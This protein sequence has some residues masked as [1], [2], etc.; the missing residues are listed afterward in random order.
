MKRSSW[1]LAGIL[2]VPLAAIVVT[3][4]RADTVTFASGKVIEDVQTTE[5]GD[6]IRIIKSDGSAMTY[7]KSMIAKIEKRATAAQEL[8]ERK[9]ALPPNDAAARVALAKWCEE[10]KMAEAAR[11]LY[12]EAVTI[13]PNCSDA[14][15]AL[16]HVKL[17]DA[18][19]GTTQAAV[20]AEL[21]GARDLAALRALVAFCDENHQTAPPNLLERILSLAPEDPDA[22]GRLG[23]VKVAG[24]WESDPKA[25]I[26]A[27]GREVAI[28]LLEAWKSGRKGEEFCGEYVP[29][30]AVHGY[31]FV[32]T[33]SGEDTKG[34][35]L[36]E[37][38]DL[39]KFRVAGMR[40]RMGT[41]NPDALL[42]ELQDMKK[43][44]AELTHA[45]E[46]DVQAIAKCLPGEYAGYHFIVMN[47]NDVEYDR[48]LILE[49]KG[50]VW[51]VIKIGDGKWRDH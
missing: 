30:R 29:K 43:E 25:I 18:W 19:F 2:S 8:P 21:P 51:K 31:R 34:T 23:H 16:G 48:Y 49:L 13:D 44:E 39:L 3:S 42:K 46:G 28:G 15:H 10:R 45:R 22:H 5:E 26:E 38:L 35:L 27:Q 7:P 36:W 20:D 6:K 11:A 37:R 33:L 14:H 50:T 12:E 9:K 4:A 24:K 47:E 17:H 1:A 41:E 40:E 32:S